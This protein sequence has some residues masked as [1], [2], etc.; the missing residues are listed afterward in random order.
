MIETIKHLSIGLPEPLEEQLLPA[1]DRRDDINRD[2]SLLQRVQV[3]APKF[4]FNE[5]GHGW[6]RQI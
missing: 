2:A 1:E 3:V 4:I 6:I 5:D